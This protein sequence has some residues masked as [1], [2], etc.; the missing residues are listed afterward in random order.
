MPDRAELT[1]VRRPLDAEAVSRKLVDRGSAWPAPET[2]STVE[3]TNAAVADAARKGAPEGL[4]LVAEEQT[5]GRGR[6]DRSW[7]SP[8]GAGLTLSVLL[9]PAPPSGTWGWLPI[10]AGLALLDAVRTLSDVDAT[11]KW[12]NDL[13]LGPAQAKG[14]GILAESGDGAVVVGIGLNVST[15]ADELPLG[16][17]SL[18]LEGAVLSRELLLVELILALESRYIAWT[19]A[20]GDAEASAL[21]RDYR[22][23]CATL[24]RAVVVQLPSGGELRGTAEAIEPSGGLQ[25]R[26]VDGTLTT[27]VAADVVH[28]RAGQ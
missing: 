27:V 26:T 12:P 2:V 20:G 1:A 16:A 15:T 10:L 11:L 22:K 24:R 5:S 7:S 3:S 6:L 17:T 19:R 25:V 21:Q 28:V 13:L 4:V 18:L 14:A 23:A 9:R 8:A